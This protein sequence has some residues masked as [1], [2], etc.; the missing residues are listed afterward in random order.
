MST[1]QTLAALTADDRSRGPTTNRVRSE[2]WAPLAGVLF[3]V[4]FAVGFLSAGD[5]PAVDAS[6]REVIAHYDDAGSILA[7]VVAAPIAAVGLL[8]F[9][10]V[11][12][13]RLR[14]EGR[15]GWPRSPSAV[16]PST[17][18]GW[19]CSQP[20]GSRSWTPPTSANPRWLR[21]STSSTLTTSCRSSSA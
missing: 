4:A 18:P 3:T 21:R 6:G 1:H 19:V 14:A 10:G 7:G 16:P 9:A 12:R 17:P 13:N 2:R 8:V 11:L 5:S 15:D 20:P